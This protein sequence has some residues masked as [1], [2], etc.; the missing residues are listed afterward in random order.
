M[1]LLQMSPNYTEWACICDSLVKPKRKITLHKHTPWLIQWV[2]ACDR[3]RQ[4]M[5]RER[6]NYTLLQSRHFQWETTAAYLK[7]LIRLY[8]CFKN[9][10]EAKFWLS[11]DTLTV[12]RRIRT[13]LQITAPGEIQPS[14]SKLAQW[15]WDTS[16]A[17]NIQK[18]ARVFVLNNFLH[19]SQRKH[20][21]TFNASS[22]TIKT[23][24]I[25]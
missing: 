1:Q 9:K 4:G 3:I 25:H 12:W 7:I 5:E 11:L 16:L 23:Q 18:Y 2:L 10:T 6:H 24:N 19:G 20:R 15:A 14:P 17:R 13:E 22:E 8:L 21:L